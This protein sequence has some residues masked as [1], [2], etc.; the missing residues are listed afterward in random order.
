L[1]ERCFFDRYG[2]CYG[3]TDLVDLDNA[4]YYNDELYCEDCC[5]AASTGSDYNEVT[6][7][8]KVGG[9]RF[10]VELEYNNASMTN[11][12]KHFGRGF[13]H[14]GF[15]YRSGILRGDGGLEATRDF[16]NHSARADWTIG[17]DCGYHLHIDLMGLSLDQL[18]AVVR[19]YNLTHYLWEGCVDPT[20][21]ATDYCS[22]GKHDLS[23]LQS[24]SNKEGFAIWGRRTGRYNFINWSSYT[25]HKTVE[26][27]GHHA[28][29]DADEVCNWI[30]A[31]TRFVDFVK[32]CS[33]ADLAAFFFGSKTRESWSE[34]IGSDVSEFYRCQKESF[35]PM[36]V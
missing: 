26:I 7:Y 13:D 15:E 9:R 18:K 19:A 30:T 27:R 36:A 20:R 8:D 35:Q 25:Y 16:V 5:P 33:D 29:L 28:T 11:E 1:C 10:G 12:H 17:Y 3:C 6:T 23:V 24:V 22:F 32:D 21:D 34:I 4:H 2:Y 31:H 14:C